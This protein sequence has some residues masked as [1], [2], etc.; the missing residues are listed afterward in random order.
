MCQ[1]FLN[2]R[3]STPVKRFSSFS[4]IVHAKALPIFIFLLVYSCL[5]NITSLVY[6]ATSGLSVMQ[7]IQIAHRTVPVH[8]TV[9]LQL[10]CLERDSV[11][12]FFTWMIRTTAETNATV[13]INWY[14]QSPERSTCGIIMY[15]I[16]L[17]VS[18]RLAKRDAGFDLFGKH[19]G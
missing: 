9:C 11:C 2:G 13:S 5:A 7:E 16:T 3:V 14:S 1:E 18:T 19:R 10:K 12:I 17:Q 6:L 4:L 8:I 15:R